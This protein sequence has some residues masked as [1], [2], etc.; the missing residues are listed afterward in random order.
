MTKLILLGAN[1]P[2]V[3]RQARAVMA[4]GDI[5]VVGFIDNDAAK[6]GAD[7]CGFPVLGGFERLPELIKRDVKFVNVITRDTP[8][9][10]ATTRQMLSSGAQLGQF[11]HPGL[12][13]AQVEYGL[14]S[15]LQEYAILQADVRIGRNCSV[16]AGCIVNHE[17]H[18]GDSVFMAPG[19]NLCGKIEV[20]DGVFV[21]AIAVVLPRLKIGAW[22]TIGAGAVVT[23]DVPAGAVVVGNP[24]RIVRY[25]SVMEEPLDVRIKA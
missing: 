10:H 15:Y 5:E 20:G 21:G 2:E 24:A 25:C 18:L 11:I 8:T 7:F 6:H 13:L 3:A 14:G 22:A 17:C 23:R 4:A 12:N 9:R 1:N 16:S 19:S